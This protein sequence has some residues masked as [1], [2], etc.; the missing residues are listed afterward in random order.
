VLIVTSLLLLL[1]QGT[2]VVAR[3]EVL[4]VGIADWA[5]IVVI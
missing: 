4:V 3:L 1:A 2:V 5:A